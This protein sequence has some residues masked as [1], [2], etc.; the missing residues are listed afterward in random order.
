MDKSMDTAD[1]N[2]C[3]TPGHDGTREAGEAGTEII[4]RKKARKLI[5]DGKVPH[6]LPDR[7]W[8]GPGTGAPCMVCGAPITREDSGL[9][10]EF[11][12]DDSA[13]ASS[14]QFH[15]RCFWVLELELGKLELARRAIASSDERPSTTASSPSDGQEGA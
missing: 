10:F 3:R 15:V 9:E 1:R 12:C 5:R 11:T 13:E 8:G 7:S 4:L 14:Q 2:Y 6:R